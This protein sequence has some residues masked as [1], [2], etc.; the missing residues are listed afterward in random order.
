MADLD[1]VEEHKVRAQRARLAQLRFAS[2]KP[3]DAP[4]LPLTQQE[5]EYLKG[6]SALDYVVSLFARSL[7]YRDYVIKGHPDFDDYVCGVMASKD[8]P[9]WIRQDPTMLRRFP[10]EALP[11]LGGGLIYRGR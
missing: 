3:C 2:H 8:T 11:G 1:P 6:G 5:R 4:E 7:A 10:P 9:D